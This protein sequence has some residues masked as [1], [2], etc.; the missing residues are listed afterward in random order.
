MKCFPG[1]A[2][3]ILYSGTRLHMCW[4][5][6][7]IEV[8]P[9]SLSLRIVS[10]MLR[11]FHREMNLQGRSTPHSPLQRQGPQELGNVKIG[12]LG[13]EHVQECDEAGNQRGEQLI[14]SDWSLRW[15]ECPDCWSFPWYTLRRLQLLN[16][17]PQL[18]RSDGPSMHEKDWRAWV[19]PVSICFFSPIM[20]L[21]Q[22]VRGVWVAASLERSWS[23]RCVLLRTCKRLLRQVYNQGHHWSGI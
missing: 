14:S 23:Y 16:F 15:V 6:P 4:Y 11:C 2:C 10:V 22:I 20:S 12:H 18:S 21:T 5:I 1:L 19:L 3:W 9:G 8:C 13:H 17:W 7:S